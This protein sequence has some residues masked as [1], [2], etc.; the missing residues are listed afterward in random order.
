MGDKKNKF[1]FRICDKNVKTVFGL[2]SHRIR[3]FELNIN[4][5]FTMYM[6]RS[7]DQRL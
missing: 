3:E 7:F 6:T 1:E 5:D 2:V 4:R